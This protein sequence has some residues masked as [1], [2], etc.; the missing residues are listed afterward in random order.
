MKQQRL[1]TH[2][3][4]L[5]FVC[6]DIIKK[7]SLSQQETSGQCR[8]CFVWPRLWIGGSPYCFSKLVYRNGK[9]LLP[10]RQHNECQHCS[11]SL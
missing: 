4:S 6:I 2:K 1:R 8:A 3:F 9:H 7:S 10:I 11:I 5:S